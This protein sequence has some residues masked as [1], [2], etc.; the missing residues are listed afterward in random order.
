M[1]ES[2]LVNG[3]EQVKENKAGEWEGGCAGEGEGE[4]AVAGG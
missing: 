3:K 2:E 4:C 1:K